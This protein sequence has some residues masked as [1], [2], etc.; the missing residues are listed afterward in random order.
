MGINLLV[1]CPAMSRSRKVRKR[2]I[3]SFFSSTL[4]ITVSKTTSTRAKSEV[5]LNKSDT[6]HKPSYVMRRGSQSSLFY[7][8]LLPPDAE[9]LGSMPTPCC[10]IP[11]VIAVLGLGH[12]SDS[13]V[14]SQTNGW[15]ALR[16][17]PSVQEATWCWQG[18]PT[19]VEAVR[20]STRGWKLGF[21]EWKRTPLE[22][23]RFYFL[24]SLIAKFSEPDSRSP[25]EATW[26]CGQ[27][28]GGKVKEIVPTCNLH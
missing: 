11:Y 13:P 5:R 23:S 28:T 16:P 20:G 26:R 3:R 22:G 6:T 24:S 14:V 10:C 27:M 25:V 7:F 15:D 21:S 18:S 19:T 1:R 2:R 8:F 17:V 4:S 9:C 12:V